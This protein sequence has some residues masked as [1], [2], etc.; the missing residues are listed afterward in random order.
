MLGI[1]AQVINANN[2]RVSP[3][4][5]SLLPSRSSVHS[6]LP[7]CVYC[8]RPLPAPLITPC[9]CNARRSGFNVFLYQYAGDDLLFVKTF[10]GNFRT[11]ELAVQ[12]AKSLFVNNYSFALC[13][14]ANS[15]SLFCFPSESDVSPAE[16]YYC[17]L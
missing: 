9:D 14:S 6:S 15:E 12:H 5:S 7:L 2:S 11:M 13:I 8:K 16:Y 3:S 1:H 4:S 17:T 10:E